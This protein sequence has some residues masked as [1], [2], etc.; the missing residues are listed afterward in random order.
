MFLRVAPS[1]AC[2]DSKMVAVSRARFQHVFRFLAR[3]FFVENLLQDISPSECRKAACRCLA[4]CVMVS[5]SPRQGLGHERG[6]L[7]QVA[8]HRSMDDLPKASLSPVMLALQRFLMENANNK[9][10]ARC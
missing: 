10:S 1:H 3:R 6:F 9:K 2:E 5:P 4:S 8:A 7:L